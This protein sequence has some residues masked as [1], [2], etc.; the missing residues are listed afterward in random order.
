MSSPPLSHHDLVR[1]APFYEFSLSLVPHSLFIADVRGRENGDNNDDRNPSFLI[2]VV[3]HAYE[4]LKK[5]M[6]GEG[7][8]G[9][10]R[11]RGGKTKNVDLYLVDDRRWEEFDQEVFFFFFF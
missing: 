7:G 3:P 6:C 2:L 10:G 8:G 9:G 1:Y 5:S 11:I 4:D